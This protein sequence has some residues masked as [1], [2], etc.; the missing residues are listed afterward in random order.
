[1]EGGLGQALLGFMR[2][3]WGEGY[4][5]CSRTFYGFESVDK[6]SEVEVTSRVEDINT[7]QRLQLETTRQETF[8]S[9]YYLYA[10]QA[11]LF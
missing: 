3:I 6:A 5:L 10:I 11:V 2:Y 8:V 4:L 1:M 9:L 7:R